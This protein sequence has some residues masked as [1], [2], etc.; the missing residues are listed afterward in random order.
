MENNTVW[1]WI[2]TAQYRNCEKY[3]IVVAQNLPDTVPV[4]APVSIYVEGGTQLYPLTTCDC[5]RVTARAIRTRTKYST[6][7]QT[8]ATGGVF[9]LL[10]KL[11]KCV[12]TNG[13]QYIDGNL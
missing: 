5:E 4:D 8:D 2:P 10:G 1:I 6:V 9:R 13:R 11:C 3:C 7:V 12:L